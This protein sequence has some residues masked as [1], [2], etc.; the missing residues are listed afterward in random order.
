MKTRGFILAT[1]LLI[2]ASLS[3]QTK[4]ELKPDSVKI[5][6]NL[7]QKI[8]DDT[9]KLENPFNEKNIQLPSFRYQFPKKEQDLAQ[10]FRFGKAYSPTYKMQIV[11][12]NFKS[13]MPVAKPDSSVHYFIQI[14]KIG[15]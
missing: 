3:A 5:G 13:N 2:A 11:R 15:K 4:Q 14:K 12:P 9:L 6:F 1:C 7:S 10:N 8:L